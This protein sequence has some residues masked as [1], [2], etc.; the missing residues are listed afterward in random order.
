MKLVVAVAAVICAVVVAV[1]AQAADQPGDG[2]LDSAAL[3]ARATRLEQRLEGRSGGGASIS[4]VRRGPRGKRGPR[5]SQGPA[6]PKGTFGTVTPVD[7]SGVTL[8]STEAFCAVQGASA[9][10]PPGT[11]VVG[12]GWKGGGIETFI[13]FSAPVGNAW[14]I[15]AI[16]WYGN[17]TINATAMCAS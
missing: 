12:G 14:N 8:C 1:G 10:C 17:P 4:T 9:P 16:N 13:S 6:G 3:E 15:I 5:G 2:T 7:G 11:T